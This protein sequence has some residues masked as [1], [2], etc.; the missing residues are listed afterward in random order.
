[1]KIYTADSNKILIDKITQEI[2]DKATQNRLENY[3]LIVPEKFSVTMEKLVLEKS[4]QHTFLNVQVVTLS[5]LLYKLISSTNNYLS[6]IMGIMA[7][8][9]VILENY[10]NLVCYKKT[11]K[12]MGFAE[13]I[14]D[15][16]SE[17]KN[18]KVS[19]EDYYSKNKTGTSLDIKLHDI[20]LLY[21]EYEKFLKRENLIDASDRFDLLSQEIYKSEYIKNSHVYIMGYDSTT[22]SGLGVFEAIARQA[23]SITCACLDNSGKGNSYICPPEMLDNYVEL[24][25]NIGIKPTVVKTMSP[26]ITFS[27]HISNN[28]YSYPYS[29]MQVGDEI[30]IYEAG[31]VLEELSVVAQDIRR[32]VIEKGLRYRDFAIVC[33]DTEAL[34]DMI[35]MV[36]SEYN[37]PYFIDVAQKLAEH[38]LARFLE[39]ALNIFRKNFSSEEV[40]SFSAN[41]FSGITAKEYSK[42][43]NYVVK[44]A[45]NYDDFKKPFI[46]KTKEVEELNTAEQVRHKLLEKLLPVGNLLKAAT[47][48][49]MYNKAVYKLFELFDVENNLEFIEKELGARNK[50]ALKDATKQV[51]QKIDELLIGAEKVFKDTKI[52]LDEYFA[53]LQSGLMSETI[54]LIPV[55]VDNIFIGDVSTSKFF[56]IKHLYVM[57]ATDGAIPRVKDDCGI[58]VDKELQLIS[59]TL[60]KKIEPTIKT[61][62]AREKFK[63][64]NILQEFS[65]KLSISYSLT[66]KTGE[67]QRPSSLVREITKIFY[68]V[69]R[70][71]PLDILKKERIDK[72]RGL[73]REDEKTNFYAHE[74]ATYDVAIKQLLGVIKKQKEGLLIEGK[75]QYDALYNVIMSNGP[76]P[77]KSIIKD[78]VTKTVKPELKN[79]NKLYFKDNKTSVSQVETYFSCPFKFFASFGLRLKARDEA[80]LKSVDYGNVLHKVA[81]LYIKNIK[82]FEID[83][84]R[85]LIEKQKEIEK[86]INFV[87]NEE[88]LK[89]ANNKYMLLQLKKE[90]FRLIDALTY[91]YRESN[92]KPLAE[93]MV[94]GSANSKYSGIELGHKIKIAGKIDRID[95][96]KDYYRVID[97]KTGYID[98]SPKTT[99]YG[100][101]VQLFAYLKAMQGLNKRLAG[102]FYLPIRN[103]FVDENEGDNYSTYKM[104]GYFNSSPDVVVNMD[105][106]LS[107][108]NNK[109]D[110][111]NISISS[112]KENK[113]TN[114]IVPTGTNALT[115]DELL[116]LSEYTKDIC[117]QAIEEILSGY[118]EPIPLETDGR[119]PCEFCE[120]RYACGRDF[121]SYSSVRKQKSNIKFE[122]FIKDTNNDKTKE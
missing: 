58:I 118:T 59:S 42:L 35:E 60:G 73:M 93:E 63:L 75:S 10:D 28:L 48:A 61:I 97:Y 116:L 16:I 81:E 12:T 121:N 53:V 100:G 18:S 80:Y 19:P 49:T 17:L 43:E 56:N 3:C 89:T 52:D 39:S 57:G 102:A 37:L 67:E 65:E 9:K 88:K 101:K 21:N 108:E 1:M 109:S 107:P 15:T 40:L 119:T 50:L 83:S 14:Y 114:Q 7:T 13:N 20:F 41:I 85:P 96:F 78:S 99:Y 92:F 26:T 4:K 2:A 27:Q 122:N 6:K 31:S 105:R 23:K 95:T 36:F 46:Y 91:Q 5:R 103:V 54:S 90:A 72:F 87:F 30:S 51:K 55:T 74:F 84:G 117:S 115:E 45:I 110:I 82:K 71:I 32:Q 47:T 34:K 29:K 22:R 66:G 86:L 11:A 112:S 113:A 44:Y 120:F 111:V 62:N 98:L 76:L 79:A 38:P 77:Y 104:L 25:Q 106:R 64:I 69:D 8:K 33:A 70:N 68:R 94:F 24:A